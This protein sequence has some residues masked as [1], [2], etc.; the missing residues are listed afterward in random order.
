MFVKLHF[1]GFHA[2]HKC[3]TVLEP[4]SQR[5][6]KTKMLSENLFSEEHK[7]VLYFYAVYNNVF[8]KIS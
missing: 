1:I 7:S 2:H 4:I 6:D 8:N 5:C 3:F